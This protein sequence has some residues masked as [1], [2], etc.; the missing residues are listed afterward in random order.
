MKFRWTPETSE[1][2]FSGQNLMACGVLY[3]IEKFL[4]LKCQKWA[5]IAH[6]NIQNTSYGQKKG[7]ESNCQFYSRPEKVRNRPHLLGCRGRATYH[8]KAL[9]DSYNFT[10][11]CISIRGMFAKLW[12]SKVAGIPTGAISRLPLRSP[13]REKPFGCRLRGQPQSIL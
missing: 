7:R 4:K 2:N 1:S 12:G 10:L 11:D 13:R 8:W 5:R 3:I 9:D 6:L